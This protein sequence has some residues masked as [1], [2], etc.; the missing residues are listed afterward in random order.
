MIRTCD[1]WRILLVYGLGVFLHGYY[2]NVMIMAEQVDD[3]D[4]SSAGNVSIVYLF[5][6]HH[7]LLHHSNSKKPYYTS[8]WVKLFDS[9]KSNGLGWWR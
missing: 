8:V 4:I 2:L 6:H 1:W 5:S 9:S 3:G 7:D